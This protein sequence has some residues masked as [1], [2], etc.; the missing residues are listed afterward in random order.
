[1]VFARPGTAVPRHQLI[2][3]VVEVPAVEVSAT[4]VR[5]RVRRGESIRYLVPEAVREYVAAHGLYR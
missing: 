5:E 3:R 4:A 1:V 2:A